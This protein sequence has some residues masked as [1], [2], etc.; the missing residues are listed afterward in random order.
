MLDRL[1]HAR[2]LLTSQYRSRVSPRSDHFAWPSS[3]ALLRVQDDLAE[4]LFQGD[5][6]PHGKYAQSFLKELISRI[7]TAVNEHNTLHP[8]QEEDEWETNG[9][10]LE[11]YT[12]LMM[13]PSEGTDVSPLA[14]HD[15]P[16]G[17]LTTYI[18]PR[19]LATS[20][21]AAEAPPS[22][23][24]EHLLDNWHGVDLMES[25]SLVEAG[26]TAVKTWE[27][28]LRLASHLLWDLVHG[29]GSEGIIGQGARVIEL[30]SGTGLLSCVI[31]KLQQEWIDNHPNEDVSNQPCI[32]STDL[33]EVVTNKLDA[34][35]RLNNLSDS[36]V[37]KLLPLNW[38]DVEE[39][40]PATLEVLHSITPTTILGA[41][42]IFDPT[43]IPSLVCT[44][45]YL[46]KIGKQASQA[47]ISSTI[48]NVETYD[49]F[50]REMNKNQL[51]FQEFELKRFA[52]EIRDEP[53]IVPFAS[54]HD[55][56][57]G[58]IVKGL[59]IWK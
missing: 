36:P 17:K 34:T 13:T 35:I 6:A 11:M 3:Y 26:S 41:D 39:Q 4:D 58:G 15:L 55:I 45:S 32:Y 53:S 27:A 19:R 57:R 49:V 46:L 40:D 5:D 14:K 42:I 50:L 23:S 18:F 22:S 25:S 52:I 38:S 2:L 10:L 1:T 54:D 47:I 31:A 7:D 9:D 48:R 51:H 16:S 21:R 20:S 59:R 12:Q 24:S 28:A 33:A 37:M 29:S 8:D 56:T 44:I 43:I 30:G